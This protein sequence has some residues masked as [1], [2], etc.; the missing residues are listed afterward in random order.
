MP[1]VELNFRL[2]G[3]NKITIA[4]WWY[5]DYRKGTILLKNYNLAGLVAPE[6]RELYVI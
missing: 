5:F 6:L 4:G 2:G 3:T 1:G